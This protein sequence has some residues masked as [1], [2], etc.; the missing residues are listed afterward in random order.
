MS[1]P[2]WV[3]IGG[4]IAL[5]APAVFAQK[6]DVKII[7]RQNSD[8][9]Y[10]AVIPGH[11]NSTSN[12]SVNCYAGSTNVNC[13]GTTQT[14]GFNTAPRAVSYSVMGSTL[15]LQLPDGRIAIVNCVS[16]YKP[17]GDHIN[18]RSCR[19]PLVDGIQAD[20]KGKDAKL[21][22]PVS[23]DGKKFESETYRIVAVLDKPQ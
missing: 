12:G 6:L 2:I 23:L 1:V 15:S 9:S 16:K 4:A 20:F 13:T 11:S 17:R 7:N 10:S 5:L 22:W 21:E 14:T 3:S 18:R 19:M 8:T